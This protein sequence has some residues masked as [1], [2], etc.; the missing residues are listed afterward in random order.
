MSA[1]KSDHKDEVGYVL[2][3]LKEGLPHGD[4]FDVK[5]GDASVDNCLELTK[6]ESKSKPVIEVDNRRLKAKNQ[7][8]TLIM[9]DPDAPSPTNHTRAPYLHYIVTNARKMDFSDGTA[10]C[11]YMGPNPPSG[12]GPHRYIFLLYISNDMVEHDNIDDSQ[13]VQYPIHEFV[14]TYNLGLEAAK[15]FITSG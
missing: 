4:I 13:R 12:S 14:R 5:Y 2:K 15:Y 9:T 8:L 10:I 11:N 1:G 3:E 6:D 7:Y